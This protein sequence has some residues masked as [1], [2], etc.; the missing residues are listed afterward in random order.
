MPA[1]DAAKLQVADAIEWRLSFGQ[2]MKHKRIAKGTQQPVFKLHHTNLKVQR[3]LNF[4][5]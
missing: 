5:C 4:S 2:K 3:W 1:C